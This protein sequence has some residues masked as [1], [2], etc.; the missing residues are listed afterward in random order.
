MNAVNV[1]PPDYIQNNFYDIIPYFRYAGVEI[2]FGAVLEKPFRPGTRD[3]I[4]RPLSVVIILRC[5]VWVEPG[6]EFH[7]PIVCFPDGKSQGDI[8]R[9]GSLALL[10]GK[11]ITPQLLPIGK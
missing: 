1:I 9:V 11:V 7:G 4:R 2:C 3:V 10:P 5:P 6:V 8:Q